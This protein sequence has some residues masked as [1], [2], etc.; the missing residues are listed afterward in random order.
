MDFELDKHTVR[1]LEFDRILEMASTFAVTGPGRTVVRKLMPLKDIDEIKRHSALIS[2][3]RKI[4]S[5]GR[6][7][8]IEHFEDL[9]SLFKKIRPSDAVLEP[10]ELTSFIPLFYSA[11]NLGILG[12][13]PSCEC[14]ATI[15]S[16]LTTHPRINQS[17][18]KSID[19]EGEIRDG[20]SPE[21]SYIRG[22]IKSSEKRIK[23]MLEDILNRKDLSP[24]LQDIYITERNNRWVI[25]VKS[26]SKG[27]VPGIVHDISNTGETVFI[28]PYSIQHPGNELESFR[29]E[30]KLEIFR[31]LKG[32]TA[33]LREHL[34][35][36]ETDYHIVAEA[37]C[38]QALAGFAEQ[39]D[40][41]SPE[42]NEKGYMKIVRGRHPLLWRALK[43]ENRES[44]LVPLDME[45]GKDN[46]CMVITGSNAGGKTV[47]LKTV[48]VLNMMALSGM[49][50]P[51]GSGTELPLLDS[52]L[53]D[54]GDEQSIEENLSTFS[55][56]ITRIAGIIRQSRAQTLVIIDELGTGTDPEQG[57]AL[58]CAVLRRLKQQGALVVVSTHLGMLKAFAHSEPGM[59]NSAMEM[60]K[61]STNNI[62]T[63]K[64][65]YKLVMGEPGTSHAFEIAES[66]GLDKD[67]INDAK[68]FMS[69]EG[70]E[71]ESLILELKRKT[72][73]SEKGLKE[74][75]RLKQEAAALRLL[76]NEELKRIKSKKQEVLSQALNEAEEILRGTKRDAGDIISRMKKSG[77]SKSRK[78]AKEIERKHEEI[79]KIRK[80]Q[81]PEEARQLKEIGE[82]RHVFIK[83]L[84]THGVIR[85]VHEKNRKCKVLVKGKEIIVP[86][87]ELYEPV[88]KEANDSAAER[89]GERPFALTETSVDISVPPEINIIGQRVDPALSVIER[90][91]NDASMAGLRQ[92]KIIHGIGT[93]RLS[94]GIR[95]YLKD[96]P[97]VE[98]VRSGDEDEGG[99][100]VTIVNL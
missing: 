86:F 33:L 21:L 57:G 15:V 60:E 40:M 83:T 50:I 87:D 27:S 99:E 45:I 31:I 19:R 71:T 14:L 12:A 58:S 11:F 76:M 32:L 49:H 16:K 42:I 68:Q 41:T 38:V 91:L 24:H 44:G 51:A 74:T 48:G 75:E 90:Y 69:G 72:S 54:I 39:M 43:K 4:L 18:E 92:V 63:Y 55:A 30:E 95:E 6:R 47:A 67:V 25:P 3:C 8:G 35:E 88:M 89:K 61:I 46:S 79:D 66:L 81:A 28:E 94:E 96:H 10:S 26:D 82:G 56:H 29:A 5:E 98:S 84:G 52:I 20:A 7:M 62:S 2:E 9:T 77:L 80:E 34:H 73:E 64:P 1:V 22:S 100:A 17:I 53:S 37:D 93:G 23:R 85:S 97:I 13:D 65:T 78:I 70:G 36:I 59:I